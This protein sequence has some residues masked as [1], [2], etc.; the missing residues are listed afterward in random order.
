MITANHTHT[1]PAEVFRAV[2]LDYGLQ[3]IEIIPDGLIRRCPTTE[4]PHSRNGWHVLY[5]DPPAGAFGD[6][7]TGLLET[8]TMKGVGQLI[9]AAGEE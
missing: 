7:A 2:L 8:W 5:S 1:N 6:W 9:F 4:K 3:P